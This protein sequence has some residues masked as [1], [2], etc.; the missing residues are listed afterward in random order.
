MANIL[1]IFNKCGRLPQYPHCLLP[2][3][4]LNEQH[5]FLTEKLNLLQ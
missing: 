2:L 3:G 5:P 1:L 4:A